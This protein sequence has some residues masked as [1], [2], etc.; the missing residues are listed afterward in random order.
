MTPEQEEAVRRALAAEP[1]PGPPPPEVVERLDETLAGLVAERASG[2]AGTTVTAGPTPLR[3]R[4]RRWPAALVAAASVAVL[5]VGVG[6]VLQDTSP[7][8]AG[9]DTA[10]T[11]RSEDAAGGEA[12]PEL[13]REPSG[14]S[15]L[16]TGGSDRRLLSLAPEPARLRSG[17]LTEDVEK[18]LARRQVPATTFDREVRPDDDV[19]GPEASLAARQLA[20]CALPDSSS[21]D[22]LVAARL[23]GERATLVLR[24]ATGETRVAEVYA[25]DDAGRLLA[26]TDVNMP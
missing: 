3:P 13:A 7:F 11:A 18:V 17:S 21:G 23:D 26:R 4:R 16:D 6:V 5:A 20:R 19:S 9:S 15:S 10:D 1:S 25:C 2:A 14:A 12:A 22:L 8:V 24:R